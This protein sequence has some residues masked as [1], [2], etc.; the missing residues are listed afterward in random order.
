MSPEATYNT[1][2]G[3]CQMM[4]RQRGEGAKT[5]FSTDE[6]IAVASELLTIASFQ[7]VDRDRLVRDLETRFTVL[8][9]RHGTLDG[10]E[11]HKPWLP[12]KSGSIQW[13]YWDRYLLYITPQLADASLRSLERVA[14]DLLERIEDP[15]RPGPWDRRGLVMG[16][17]QSGKTANYIGLVAKAADAGYKVI[18]VLTGRHNSL[19]SQTQIRL[20][21][22]FLGFRSQPRANEHLETFTPVGVGKLDGSVKANTG[23]NRTD[24][25][26]FSRTVANQF[27][28]NPGGLPLLFVVKKD[29]RVLQNLL[30]WIRS[31]ADAVEED[32][33]RR[34][35]RNVP[36]LLIDD[37]ADVASIDTRAQAFNDDSTPDPDHDPTIINGLIRRILRSFDKAAYVGYTATPFANIYIDDR[38]FTP[39][40]GPDLF[41]SSFIINLPPPN[42][43]MGPAR[44]FGLAEDE[45]AGLKG[46]P[47][48]PV[49]RV[50]DDHAESEDPAEENGWMPP[51]LVN[52]TDHVPLFDGVRQVPPS[53]RNAV[54]SYILAI[55]VRKIRRAAAHHN[56][57]LVHVVRYTNVQQIVADEL[58]ALLKEIIQRLRLGDG[59]R[60]PTL[61]E[62]LRRL[63]A[64][65]FIPTNARCAEILA[66]PNVVEDLPGWSAVDALLLE[67]AASVK[68][69]V[70]NGT[71]GD[72]LDYDEHRETGLNLIAVGGDKLARGL[73]LEGLTVSYFLRSSQMY[74]TL[75]QMGRWF[76]YRD[77]YI[78][79]CRLYTT[80]EIIEWFTHVAAASEELRIEFD[81][82]VNSGGTPKYYGLKVRSHPVLLVT[83][84]VKMRSGTEMKVAYGGDIS[85]TII[86]DRDENWIARNFQATE[87]WL[88]S[89]GAPT[90][91][92]EKSGALWTTTHTNVLAFLSAYSSHPLALRAQTALLAKYIRR[93]VGG[94][95]E[96]I[97]WSVLL[98]SS[99]DSVHRLPIAGQN[100]GLIQRAE[101]PAADQQR[102][103]R[104]TIRRL[105]SPRDEQRD[106][107]GAQ[108]ETALAA[109]I[110]EWE[111]TPEDR[112]RRKERPTTPSGRSLREVRPATR[113]LLMLYLLD[114]AYAR[115]P[116]RRPI[117]GLAVSFPSSDNAEEITYTVNNVFTANGDDPNAL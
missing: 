104:Y 72:I 7:E 12:A 86:F 60:E 109:T 25:G 78:D 93:M 73:T 20:D 75:M 96:L 31:S 33:D 52:K 46:V 43:Y 2:L 36:L 49:V 47:P 34:Y 117:V 10:D 79:L 87:A 76:G 116:D 22:G 41:P 59:E 50:V 17:V 114:P 115:M 16:S 71:A 81:H 9:P 38:S 51:R 98:C 113:G 107:T 11:G 105:V 19:R 27:G 56:S 5:F 92:Y 55:A 13:R 37:E 101:Y 8:S 57:M 91:T 61:R 15:D 108:I 100:L 110:A 97:E 18:I 89:L 112:R 42:N 88:K 58:D 99:A 39:E 94:F 103:D 30:A 1:A 14:T 54:Y 77:G 6:I 40:L 44:V 102:H 62:D 24:R 95:G 21:E 48:L 66:P 69:R 64:D 53:L 84:A 67:S 23:T 28:I 45:E 26:D 82:M 4:L 111:Q 90:Q 29:A 68:I 106:L 32:T 3:M 70:V 35:V 65:D 63:W 85:E 83:S 80:T 74:D